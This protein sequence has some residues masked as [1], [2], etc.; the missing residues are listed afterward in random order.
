MPTAAMSLIIWSIMLGLA[1]VLNYFRYYGAATI[2]QSAS[3]GMLVV[4]LFSLLM[5]D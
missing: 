2:V 5:G 3:Y 1:F 4:A